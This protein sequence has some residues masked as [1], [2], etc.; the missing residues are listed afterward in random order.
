[1]GSDGRHLALRVGQDR[2]RLRA[3]GFGKADWTEQ[4]GTGEGQLF[5]FAFKPVI[6]DFN[7]MRRV[8]L[9]LIDFRPSR[10]AAPASK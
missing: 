4:L 5:D 10:C 6:N 3:V 2:T 7:G 9:Q 1:M 8:E